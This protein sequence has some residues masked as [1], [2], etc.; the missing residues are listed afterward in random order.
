VTDG[1]LALDLEADDEEEHRQQRVV[2]PV[3]ERHAKCAV[4]ER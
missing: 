1:E 3:Q 4:A 2:D